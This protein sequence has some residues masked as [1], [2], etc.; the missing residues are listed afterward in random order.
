MYVHV[1]FTVLGMHGLWVG[2]V[3]LPLQ[4]SLSHRNSTQGWAWLHTFNLST[5]DHCE[6]EAS[7]VYMTIPSQ[8]G[9]YGKT[10]F[11][12]KNKN[13]ASKQ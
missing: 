9:L 6:F 10:L 8:P 4:N 3:F 7:L 2:V 1:P 5:K 11:Q 12:N 13:Q